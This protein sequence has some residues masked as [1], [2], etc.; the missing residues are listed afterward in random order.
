M[1][2]LV[3]DLVEQLGVVIFLYPECFLHKTGIDSIL[4]PDLLQLFQGLIINQFLI[5]LFTVGEQVQ[6]VLPILA[7]LVF[8]F[9]NGCQVWELQFHSFSL[10]LLHE[11]PFPS[12]LFLFFALLL[13]LLKFF[14]S[15][16]FLL[17]PLLF[18]GFLPFPFL[19]LLPEEVE[20]IINNPVIAF[21]H[22]IGVVLR[23]LS[24]FVMLR[25]RPGFVLVIGGVLEHIQMAEFVQVG[26][27]RNLLED[28]ILLLL[29][30][31]TF[32]WVPILQVTTEQGFAEE[33]VVVAHV[34]VLQEW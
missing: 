32:G 14:Q 34:L 6:R 30:Y 31:F 5:Y 10:V 2:V 12:F 11:L 16:S 22:P 3:D 33:R 29:A 21:T 13:L 9:I 7:I 17:P 24:Q 8:H 27:P 19:L 20:V 4:L 18:F 25:Q 15:P 28:A 1:I 26:K 23:V